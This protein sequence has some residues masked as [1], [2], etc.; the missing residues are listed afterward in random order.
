[1]ITLFGVPAS[2][3]TA[4]RICLEEIGVDYAFV[5]ITREP[6]GPP[7]FVAASP[8]LKVPALV[9]EQLTIT[10]SAAVTMYLSDRFADAG[11]APPP[12]D[13]LRA[14]W[15][16]WLMCLTTTLQA[17]LY[18]V[19]YPQRFGADRLMVGRL[20]HVAEA[21]VTGV[22]DWLEEELAGRTYLVGERFTSADVFL[23]ML[24]PWTRHMV[25]PGFVRPHTRA[26]FERI[27]ERPAI[28]RVIALEGIV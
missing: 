25:R 22:L 21:H 2:A 13:P 10:E 12:Q 19:I 4:P 7:A 24:L 23:W 17:P 8:H 14:D 20:R 1:M 9:D 6:P 16:R 28:A 26:Y 15:Y 11:L 18:Q 27:A 5:P 3:S